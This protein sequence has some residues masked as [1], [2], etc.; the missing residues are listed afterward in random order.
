MLTPEL[1]RLSS[2]K[3]SALAVRFVIV[4]A[5]LAVMLVPGHPKPILVL[6][7]LAGIATA[8][9]SPDRG[10]PALALIAGIAGWFAGSGA[11]GS[12]S[13]VRVACF[14]IALY[15]LLSST[16]LAAAVPVR[17][18][19]E[20]QA[21]LRWAGRWL[22]HVGLA[23]AFAALSYGIEASIDGYGSYQIELA[24]L[25]GVVAVVGCVVWLFTRSP[26]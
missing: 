19:L 13:F 10:G 20:P 1:A 25:L 5:G 21:A 7:M 4:A 22:L 11:H 24:G 2:W 12:P 18:R 3:L 26:R 8:A 6:A 16:A 9:T 17:A 23:A 15:L 14:A